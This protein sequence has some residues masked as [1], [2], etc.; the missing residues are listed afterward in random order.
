[1]MR[2]C[3]MSGSW[4]DDPMCRESQSHLLVASIAAE[5]QSNLQRLRTEE[6]AACVGPQRGQRP[7]VVGVGGQ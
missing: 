6:V 4:P 1:M 5:L 2:A 3:I 7:L